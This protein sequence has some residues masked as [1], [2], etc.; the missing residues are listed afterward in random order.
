MFSSLGATMDVYEYRVV[1]APLRGKKAKGVRGGPARFAYALQEVMN[2]LGRDGWEYL[3]S[4]TLPAEER[5]GL[6]GR[7][8]TYQNM[9][10]FQRPVLNE[11]PAALPQKEIKLIE[12]QATLEAAAL[13]A[14]PHPEAHDDDMIEVEVIETNGVI[15][16]LL[17]RNAPIAQKALGQQ[18]SVTSA[19]PKPEAQIASSPDGNETNV[20]HLRPAVS[21]PAFDDSNNDENAPMARNAMRA[22]IGPALL[23]RANQIKGRI[24]AE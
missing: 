9:L 19:P 2:E 10:V 20:H 13:V 8:T 18:D 21:E 12:K 15:T 23:M 16:C 7:T 3:R 22:A 17:E 4:D 14:Q 11:A 6:T 1:P 5:V 24:A